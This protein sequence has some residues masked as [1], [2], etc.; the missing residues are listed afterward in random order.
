MPRARESRVGIQQVD[1][2]QHSAQGLLH[3]QP[4]WTVGVAQTVGTGGVTLLVAAVAWPAP[5]CFGR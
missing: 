1:S 2:K 4:A 3:T 5:C